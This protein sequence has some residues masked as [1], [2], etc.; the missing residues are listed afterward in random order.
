[1]TLQSQ[2]PPPFDDSAGL[3]DLYVESCTADPEALVI[4]V[5]G[6]VDFASEPVLREALDRALDERSPRVVVDLD[7]VTFM[8]ATTLNL[9]VETGHRAA[10]A[11]ACLRV[12]CRTD[13]G[14]RLFRTVGLDYLLD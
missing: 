5:R 2:P 10:A 1:M 4:T 7:A 8:D 6:E 12:R 14:R 9:L 13:P 11:G 3:D